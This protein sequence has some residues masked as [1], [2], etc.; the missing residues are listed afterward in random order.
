M[1]PT[2]RRNTPNN[3]VGPTLFDSLD[4]TPAAAPLSNKLRGG[5]Y[6]PSP[7]AE[8]LCRWAIRTPTDRVLEPSCG[9]GAIL[10]QAGKRLADL[11]STPANLKR[12][13]V[14]VELVA[15]E[16]ATAE[17]RLAA[18]LERRSGP[19]VQVADFFRWHAGTL[20]RRRSSTLSSATRRSSVT[21]TSPN[22]PASWRCG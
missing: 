4:D 12:Q 13:L 10:V 21:R 5:Y 3:P 19:T 14:G 18:A 2:A 17:R 22:R 15:S 16:A 11:G 7:I 8:W 9:D 6:T 20:T 1:P